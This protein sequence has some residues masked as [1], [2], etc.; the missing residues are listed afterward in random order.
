[1]SL[2]HL[3]WIQQ[4]K[5]ELLRGHPVLVSLYPHQTGLSYA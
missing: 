2:L 4:E 3:W 1:M 5:A